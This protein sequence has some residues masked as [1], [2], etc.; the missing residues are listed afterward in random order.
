MYLC[1]ITGVPL[2]NNMSVCLT[3]CTI[4]LSTFRP[5]APRTPCY[6]VYKI[7]FIH[8]SKDLRNRMR[9]CSLSFKKNTHKKTTTNNN[10]NDKL[11]IKN[12]NK[13]GGGGGSWGRFPNVPLKYFDGLRHWFI[14]FNN[15]TGRYDTRNQTSKR[16]AKG[17]FSAHV[18]NTISGNPPGNVHR[19]IC[20]RGEQ[21]V[22]ISYD[23]HEPWRQ[24]HNSDA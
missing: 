5:Q 16:H 23:H 4:R 3:V 11:K 21:N 8:T 22:S 17:D 14:K 10:N 6:L 18:R 20:Y 1:L 7:L 2:R 15:K 24:L 9:P 12:N 13:R 19:Y